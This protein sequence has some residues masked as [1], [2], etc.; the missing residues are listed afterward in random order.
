MDF[1]VIAHTIYN[2]YRFFYYNIGYIKSSADL[3]SVNRTEFFFGKRMLLP[4]TLATVKVAM[5]IY[6]RSI[7]VFILYDVVKN[8]TSNLDTQVQRIKHTLY[9]PN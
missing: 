9:L 7:N 2:T 1:H 5:C 3:N 8:K 4:V 6:E